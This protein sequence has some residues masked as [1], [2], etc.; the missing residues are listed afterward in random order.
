[1]RS[2]LVP[3]TVLRAAPFELD[4]PELVFA[5][6]RSMNINGWSSFSEINADGAKILT[7]P[8]TV[9]TPRRGSLTD[10]NYIHIEWDALVDDELRGSEITSYYLQWD[11]GTAGL[12]WY[13]L[14]GL[15]DPYLDLEYIATYGDITPGGDY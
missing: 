5:K 15:S 2:C 9:G 4:Y 12:T 10:E 14:V 8:T 7:E 11:K 1:M 6:V 3:L 13:D